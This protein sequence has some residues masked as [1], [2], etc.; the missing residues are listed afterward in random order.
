MDKQYINSSMSTFKLDN[1]KMTDPH[2]SL[3]N[4]GYQ[5]QFLLQ[6][7]ASQ[8]VPPKKWGE[9]MQTQYFKERQASNVMPKVEKQDSQEEFEAPP[10]FKPIRSNLKQIPLIQMQQQMPK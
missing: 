4:L 1:K 9:A 6:T 7:G 3:S 2:Q 5:Q 10:T 8:S